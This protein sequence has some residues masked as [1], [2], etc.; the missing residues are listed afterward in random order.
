MKYV[1]NI[2]EPSDSQDIGDDPFD[3]FVY[4]QQM[5][6]APH[7]GELV[8]VEGCNHRVV[9]CHVDQNLTESQIRSDLTYYKVC[10]V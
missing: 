6:D 2:Y 3:V 10:V 5:D 9:A 1:W 4:S 7:L 8:Y